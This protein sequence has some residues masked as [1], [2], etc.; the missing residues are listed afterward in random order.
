[1]GDIGRQM[2]QKTRHI[3]STPKCCMFTLIEAISSQ[4]MHPPLEFDVG[5]PSPIVLA[6]SPLNWTLNRSYHSIA[7]RLSCIFDPLVLAT[8]LA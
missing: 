4:S 1:M 8:T 2:D 7:W 6:P 5:N 3:I